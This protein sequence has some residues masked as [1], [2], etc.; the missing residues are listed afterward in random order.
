MADTPK[1]KQLV[2]V[3]TPVS[4]SSNVPQSSILRILTAGATGRGIAG[5][6]DV[7]QRIGLVQQA[8]SDKIE[9]DSARIS[10]MSDAEETISSLA[11]SEQN[12]TAFE[13]QATKG[14]N[15]IFTKAA[16][17]VGGRNRDRFG[18]IVQS[19]QA[20]ASK[21]IRS[22]KTSKTL[23]IAKAQRQVIGKNI[24]SRAAQNI[25]N[26][27]SDSVAQDA[28]LKETAGFLTS[29]FDAGLISADGM[30]ADL[31][32]ADKDLTLL[33]VDA[34][35]TQGKSK[36]AL[37]VLAKSNID[38]NEK[39]SIRFQTA[40]RINKI[41]TANNKALKAENELVESQYDELSI[42]GELPATSDTGLS[43]ASLRTSNLSP[44]AKRRINAK[45]QAVSDEGG[46]GDEE[47]K[48]ILLADISDD[49]PDNPI[50]NN[51]YINA[52][53]YPGPTLPG[54][55][56]VFNIPQE[57]ELLNAIKAKAADLEGRQSTQ[58]AL[59]GRRSINRL[60]G[61]TGLL[62]SSRLKRDAAV[63]HDKTLNVYNSGLA[64]GMT[65]EEAKA[66]AFK[67]VGPPPKI[68]FATESGLAA[69]KASAIQL[70]K[71]I[72]A[73][74]GTKRTQS[75]IDTDNRRIKRYERDINDM[76]DQ[77]AIDKEMNEF[78]K[79]K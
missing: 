21:S 50:I 45:N 8:A 24:M 35:M 6:G 19:A 77:L 28:A 58:S 5:A 75:E 65:A 33:R 13:E 23:D 68:L 72:K 15:K 3:A 78:V 32:K 38:P 64:Q 49:V 41:D 39:I 14:L 57:K 25:A 11:A 55:G 43:I 20:A 52:I 76:I 36:E 31:L 27:P 42:A 9:L 26:N 34:L 47:M 62:G 44:T 4:S 71:D 54:T 79:P 7:L 60:Y 12:P 66:N 1:S 67:I 10:L 16:K 73:N 30:T 61:T 29:Q 40:S 18:V 48:N 22:I 37:D 74:V 69:L 17:G 51:D 70:G 63:K 56:K 46:I 2:P 53:Q 59:Q